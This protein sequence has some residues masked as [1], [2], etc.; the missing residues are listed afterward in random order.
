[1][2]MLDNDDLIALDLEVGSDEWKSFRKGEAG[3]G[4]PKVG[5]ST[6][7]K[8]MGLNPYVGPQDLWLYMT[9]RAD[10]EEIYGDEDNNESL[11]WGTHVEPLILKRFQETR[12]DLNVYPEHRTFQSQERP[13]MT[14]SPDG[15]AQPS[16]SG[17][18]DRVIEAKC[19]FSVWRQD[20]RVDISEEDSSD[21]IPFEYLCQAQ[22]NAGV[23]GLDRTVVPARLTTS[24]ESIVFNVYEVEFDEEL[25]GNLVDKA[26]EFILAVKNDE[27]PPSLSEEDRSDLLD[28]MYNK[29]ESEDLVED[30]D[31]DVLISEFR[32]VKDEISEIEDDF[33]S[34]KDEQTKAL[35]EKKEELENEI[36]ERIGDDLGIKGEAFRAKWTP[37][38][39]WYI[40]SEAIEVLEDECPELL[41]ELKERGLIYKREYRNLY[42]SEL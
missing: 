29:P 16:N 18:I 33:D 6:I 13:W 36:K 17:E 5:G 35:R 12:P 3:D 2:E 42:D 23:L 22:W 10:E 39:R 28:R 27:R 8:I 21:D 14:C 26:E 11:W 38:T 40:K 37:I 15:F 19:K 7:S 1:M 34:R 30:E 4:V 24:K 9:G 25:F 32:E 31:A 20:F 41:E